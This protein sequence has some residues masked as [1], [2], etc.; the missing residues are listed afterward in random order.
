M[1][2][3]HSG[4]EQPLLR[5]GYHT[6]KMDGQWY[7]HMHIYSH[8]QI[9]WMGSAGWVCVHVYRYYVSICHHSLQISVVYPGGFSRCIYYRY[10]LN[11]H[12]KYLNWMAC[13]HYNTGRGKANSPDIPVNL[14]DEPS[15]LPQINSTMLWRRYSDCPVVVA[16]SSSCRSL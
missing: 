15:D 12:V 10:C 2:I 3:I 7:A 5:F 13:V 1:F 9:Y 4:W 14:G 8:M 16:M 6:Y 11:V